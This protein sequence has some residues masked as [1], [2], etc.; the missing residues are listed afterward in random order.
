MVSYSRYVA[1]T[2]AI[3]QLKNTD[4]GFPCQISTAYRIE[5]NVTVDS[6][7][8]KGN[9]DVYFMQFQGTLGFITH[10]IDFVR[11]SQLHT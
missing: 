6:D 1:T 4:K 7:L 10:S 11:N 3:Q 9:G 2:R 5:C 8:R